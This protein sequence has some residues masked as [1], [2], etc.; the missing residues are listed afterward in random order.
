MLRRRQRLT[1]EEQR[2]AELEDAAI[3]QH[4]TLAATPVD[5]DAV[6]GTQVVQYPHAT[7]IDDASMRRGHALVGDGHAPLALVAGI[8]TAKRLAAAELD[9]VETLEGK[10]PRTQRGAVTQE[11]REQLGAATRRTAPAGAVAR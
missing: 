10:A 7:G 2:V 11:G 5:V 9:R 1:V 8:D 3:L 6:L 4:G